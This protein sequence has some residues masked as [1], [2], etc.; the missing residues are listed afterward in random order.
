MTFLK[1]TLAQIRFS[2]SHEAQRTCRQKMYTGEMHLLH[3]WEMHCTW[4]SEDIL[5]ILSPDAS[6]I[7]IHKLR[8]NINKKKKTRA[9]EKRGSYSVNLRMPNC[10]L[11]KRCSVYCLNISFFPPSAFCGQRKNR[12][13]VQRNMFCFVFF[14][15]HL[16][17]KTFHLESCVSTSAP[18]GSWLP[19]PWLV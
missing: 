19:R 6:Y 17:V 5:S 13:I 8:H 11:W 15:A 4:V 1:C 2:T 12:F 16:T 10:A 9:N 18:S 7:Y 14:T 3:F